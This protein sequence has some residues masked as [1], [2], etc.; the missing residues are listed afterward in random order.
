MRCVTCVLICASALV[1]ASAR[2][3]GLLQ[4]AD[5]LKLR[6]VTEV[7][8]SKDAT[9][10]AYIVESNDGAGRPYGQLWVMTLAD[11]KSV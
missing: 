11:G 5:L 8:L 10:A 9:R 4:S 1:S 7:E 2:G 6:S 3:Q